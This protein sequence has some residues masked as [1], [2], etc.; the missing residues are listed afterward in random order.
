MCKINWFDLLLLEIISKFSI[1]KQTLVL[2]VKL[3]PTKFSNVHLF[4][5]VVRE[6]RL[7]DGHDAQR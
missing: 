3:W 5:W 6:F 2:L 1:Y 7:V 4:M